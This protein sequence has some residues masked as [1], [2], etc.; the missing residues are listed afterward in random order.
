[1]KSYLF[2][3]AA[4]SLW[5]L[6]GVFSR[7][8]LDAGVTPLEIAFWR[9]LLAGGFFV[10]HAVIR[11]GLRL[12]RPVDAVT[13]AGF[14]LIGVVLFFSSLTIAIDAG[15]VSLAFILLYTA[16]V[17]VL[18]FAWLL[19]G[20]GMTLRKLVLTGLTLL[21]VLL[22]TQSGEGGS[23]PAR[24][25]AW[26][27]LA[28]LSYASYYIFG[29]R[30]LVRYAPVTIYAFILPLGAAGLLPFVSFVPKS[31]G[32]W[33]LLL[34]LAFVSTYL[35]YLLYYTGL[36]HAQASRAVLVATLEPVVALLLA[37]VIIGERLGLA[38][39]AG[40]VLVLAAAV[41][42]ALP[43]RNSGQPELPA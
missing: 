32:V 37:G 10:L 23:V 19:L 15:G 6:I 17:F 2:I 21:G 30:L 28:G 9:A 5:A 43:A 16:P 22:V 8:V 18:L 3:A 14:A 12:Q 11:G 33:L 24:A 36:K 4:A 41:L 7:G 1:V 42:S 34:L 39:I 25:L 35:A 29:K 20:E 31:P 26:G 27:L 13:F 40:S 38:G